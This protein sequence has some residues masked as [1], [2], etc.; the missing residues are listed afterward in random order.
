MKEDSGLTIR[1][2]LLTKLTFTGEGEAE[3]I[4]LTHAASQSLKGI[5]E[6]CKLLTTSG[7]VKSL[8]SRT[9]SVIK[10]LA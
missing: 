9:G 1:V 4:P 6:S 5:G 3:H 10:P 2:L 8:M 7:M